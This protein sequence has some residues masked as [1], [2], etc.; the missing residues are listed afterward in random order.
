MYPIKADYGDAQP[1]TLLPPAALK[2]KAASFL[3]L[4]TVTMTC[5]F[6]LGLKYH[7][8]SV[9]YFDHYQQ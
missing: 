2:L 9:W 6:L 7:C 4:P 8:A 1:A 3:L 5:E